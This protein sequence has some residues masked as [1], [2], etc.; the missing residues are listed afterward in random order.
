MSELNHSNS[1]LSHSLQRSTESLK[2]NKKEVQNKFS[3]AIK[4]GN[5]DEV[6]KI[7]GLGINVDSKFDDNSTA[8]HFAVYNNQIEVVRY[9]IEINA[10]VNEKNERGLTPLH[11]AAS[12]GNDLAICVL[13]ESGANPN[14]KDTQVRIRCQLL[15]LALSY[16][17]TLRMFILNLSYTF[18]FCS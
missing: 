2:L 15:Q 5:I 16:I 14:C 9:L 7:I 10:S 1:T 17:L 8:L 13:I 3:E 11:I 18:T 6:A 12:E 4:A